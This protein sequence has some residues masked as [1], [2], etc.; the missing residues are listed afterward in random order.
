MARDE[1]EFGV[2]ASAFNAAL[3]DDAGIAAARSPQLDAALARA[4]AAAFA[5]WPALAV[6]AHALAAY[7]G[8]RVD[9]KP[10]QTLEVA[11]DRLRAGDLLL[12][13]ACA[14]GDASALAT[15][16]DHCLAPLHGP[17]AAMGASPDL[18]AELKQDLRDLLLVPRADQPAG[19]CDFAGKGDLRGWVRVIAVREAGRR[20]RAARRESDLG[21]EFLQVVAPEHDPEIAFLQGTYQTEFK[22]AFRDAIDALEPRQRTLLR[23]HVLDGLNIEQ[24]GAMYQVHKT[25]SFRWLEKARAD[26]LTA[27]RRLLMQRL[28]VTQGE[29]ESILRLIHSHVELDARSVLK[30]RT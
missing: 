6:P 2:A 22:A 23:Y 15:F 20:L 4:L 11:L 28:K 3:R 1:E 21:D 26:L 18:I 19:I 7:L 24:I 16:D 29:V 9:I 12:T 30:T 27:T 17:L 14:R 13:C 10:D 25:T 8:A 5:T